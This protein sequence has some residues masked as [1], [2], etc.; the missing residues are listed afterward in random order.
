M[1]HFKHNSRE[2]ACPDLLNSLQKAEDALRKQLATALPQHSGHMRSLSYPQV[3]FLLTVLRVETLRASTGVITPM[4]AYFEH[5]GV[6]KSAIGSS[7]EAVGRQVSFDVSIFFSI[8]WL[9][10]VRRS[11]PC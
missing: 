5:E 8:E 9:T 4:L 7:L 10:R 2:D 11:L 3:V 1:F 6:N